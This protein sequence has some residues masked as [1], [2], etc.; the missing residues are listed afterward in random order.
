MTPDQTPTPSDPQ[1]QKVETDKSPM[2]GYRGITTE[3]LGEYALNKAF[4]KGTYPH[5]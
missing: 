2:S 5:D 4:A 3:Q 1:P